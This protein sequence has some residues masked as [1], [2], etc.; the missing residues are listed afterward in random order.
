MAA[1]TW[2]ISL[3]GDG[4]GNYVTTV[5]KTVTISGGTS[6]T[7]PT[8][9]VS[10]FE[11]LVAAL[12]RGRRHVARQFKLGN[13]GVSGVV[14]LL[15]TISTATPPA[16][17]PSVNTAGTPSGTNVALPTHEVGNARPWPEAL[18]R[19]VRWVLNRVAQGD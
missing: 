13:V 19:G 16:Y 9:E 5:Q 8:G 3:T 14:N 10:G 6:R 17:T 15:T 18:E 11:Q 1:L 12:E 4:T 7:M 2:N